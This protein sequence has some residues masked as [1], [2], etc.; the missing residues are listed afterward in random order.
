MRK[1]VVLVLSLLLVGAVGLIAGDHE[2]QSDQ[3]WFD[4]ENCGMCKHLKSEAG[5]MD[6]MTW[7]N[8]KI[9]TGMVSVTTVEPGWEDKYEKVNQK[10][11]A[12]GEKLMKGEQM[13]LCGMCTDFGRIMMTG[14]VKSDE[15]HTEGGHI[16]TVTS[17]D[18][19]VIKM[20]H[21]HCDRTNAEYAKMME[22]EA[23][24]GHDH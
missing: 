23:H 10:M 19:E 3:P 17:T 8:Y 16:W 5:L 20:I 22:Q 1:S 21:A 2:K 7:E 6:H 4:M 18:P 15:L 11:A 14:K 12:T 13:H 24:E 9:G